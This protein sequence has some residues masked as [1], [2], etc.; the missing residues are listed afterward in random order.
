MSG[1]DF[2]WYRNS[3]FKKVHF[4]LVFVFILLF[5]SVDAD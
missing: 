3:M 5:G 2:G 1:T 4:S